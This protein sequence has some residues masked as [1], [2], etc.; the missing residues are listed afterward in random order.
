MFADVCWT[1]GLVQ[2]PQPKWM[3]SGSSPDPVTQKMNKDPRFL[4]ELA[5]QP[6]IKF[7]HDFSQD[8]N[9]YASTRSEVSLSY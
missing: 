4:I 3:L 2:T 9:T 1:S 6:T 8:E 5:C 7:T